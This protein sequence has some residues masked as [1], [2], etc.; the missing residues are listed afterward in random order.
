[1]RALRL[2]FSII[3]GLAAAAILLILIV[4]LGYLIS[5]RTNGHLV[6]S[7]EKRSYL[8]YVPRSLDSS[9]PVPLVLVFHGF[10]QWPANQARVSQWNS[11]ADEEGFIVVYPSGT[12]FPKRWRGAG[13]NVEGMDP[14]IDVKF[15]SDL[16]DKLEGQF[17]IDAARIYATGLSN[18]GGMS[19][20]VSCTLSDR[21]A[22]IGGV[23]GAYLYPMPQCDRSRPVAMM[24]V[25]GDADPIVPYLGGPSHSFT[26]PFPSIPVWAKEYAAFNSCKTSP[27]PISGLEEDVT[28]IHYS[29]C[30]QQADVDFYTILGGGHSW[31]GGKPLPKWIVGKTSQS[32]DTTRVMWDFFVAHPLK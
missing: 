8:L 2:F 31:P 19:F 28:G 15:V 13:I 23:A 11:L 12:G 25:H 16:I 27:E 32:F 26:I 3:G 17:N 10:A 5:N 1:M 6:S 21:I 30:D 7:G 14:L 18:G 4:A 22:A 9:T 20:L 24:L 29:G